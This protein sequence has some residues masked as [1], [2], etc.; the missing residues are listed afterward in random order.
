MTRTPHRLLSLVMAA[1][2]TF[3]ALGAVSGLAD[4]RYDDARTAAAV[5]A[6]VAHAAAADQRV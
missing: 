6:P 5:A 3:T 4:S 1:F 2:V